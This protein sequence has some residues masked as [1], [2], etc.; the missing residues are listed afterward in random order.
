MCFCVLGWSWWRRDHDRL[1]C[2]ITDWSWR[3]RYGKNLSST[4]IWALCRLHSCSGSCLYL[5]F[6]LQDPVITNAVLLE[7]CCWEPGKH[8]RHGS[9]CLHL[10][11]GWRDQ[12]SSTALYYLGQPCHFWRWDFNRLLFE[13]L[14]PSTSALMKLTVGC[15]RTFFS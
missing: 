2:C 14:T 12:Y 6:F 5:V 15:A 13:T 10:Q 4:C 8:L 7:A 1:C 3:P 9:A 11:F